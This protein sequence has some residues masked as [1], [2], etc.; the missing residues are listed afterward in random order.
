MNRSKDQTNGT[1]MAMKVYSTPD[2]LPV[3]SIDHFDT[4]SAATMNNNEKTADERP[5]TTTSNMQKQDRL[6]SSINLFDTF[7]APKNNNEKIANESPKKTTSNT[8]KQESDIPKRPLSAYNLFF[9]LVSTTLFHFL[10]RLFLFLFTDSSTTSV[11][12]GEGEHPQRRGGPELHIRERRKN[13]PHSLQAVSAGKAEKE[14]PQ[15]TRCDRLSRTCACNCEQMEEA[16][17]FR[18]ASVRRASCH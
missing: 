16:G 4:F 18:E 10:S 14:A 1:A 5:K 13:R 12:L 6:M 11:L 9:Q 17:R 7:H 3:N 8:Q 15:I 2:R